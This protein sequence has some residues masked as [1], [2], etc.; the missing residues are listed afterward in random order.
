MLC[1]TTISEF[2]QSVGEK[3]SELYQGAKDS[4]AQAVDQTKAAGN[5][6]GERV[7]QVSK[8]K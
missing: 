7:H 2:L 6:A 3:A 5:D 8:L 4:A 1:L